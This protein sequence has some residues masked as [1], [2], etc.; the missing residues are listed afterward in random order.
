MNPNSVA[1]FIGILIIFLGASMCLPLGVALVDGD[2]SSYALA[3]SMA[4]TECVGILMFLSAKKYR[5]MHLSHRDGVAIVTFGWLAAGLFGAIPF[6]ISGAIPDFSSA[7][8]ESVSGFTTTGATVLQNIEAVSPGII[9]WRS[10]TQWIGGMGIIVLSIAI[11][12]FLGVGGMQLYKA[13]IPSPVVDKLKPRISDTSKTLWKFY[14]ILPALEIIFLSAGGMPISDSIN[15]AFCTMPTGGYLKK[16]KYSH[17]NSQ[18][19][20]VYH[21]FHVIAGKNFFTS[22][23]DYILRPRTY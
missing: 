10:I 2:Q 6:I 22:L 3:W 8:F 9:L 4:I 21:V 14:I 12:P 16:H 7:C 19:L 18:I 1:R 15:H 17:Y 20:I 13:E 11:L 5:V 23:Q